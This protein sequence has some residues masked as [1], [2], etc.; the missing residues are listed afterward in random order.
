MTRYY[1]NK[2]KNEQDE[3]QKRLIIHLSSVA[4]DYIKLNNIYFPTKRF[5]KILRR[6]L[7]IDKDVKQL[8][9]K[10]GYVSTPMTT[11]KPV[12]R[13]VSSAEEE[14]IAILRAIGY[15]KETYAHPKHIILFGVL[16]NMIPTPIT[17]AIISG[18]FKSSK[19]TEWLREPKDFNLNN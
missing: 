5:N 10:P 16:Y 13:T 1:M 6:A 11:N 19:K 15:L 14:S 17:D 4:G 8:I 18:K 2:V 9:I 3:D 12:G 7:F